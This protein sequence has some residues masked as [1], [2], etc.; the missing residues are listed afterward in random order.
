[1][2]PLCKKVLIL[3][4]SVGL[5]ESIGSPLI[6]LMMVDLPALSSPRKRIRN[7]RSLTDKG[8]H[9]SAAERHTD[10]LRLFFLI[11]LKRPIVPRK[12]L[13][14]RVAGTDVV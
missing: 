6:F 9:E 7:S 5:I 2:Y 3:K 13:N 10:Y 8:Q 11:M 14:Q 1:M 12:R 4:P